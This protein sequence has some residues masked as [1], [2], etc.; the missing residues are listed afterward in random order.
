MERNEELHFL[1]ILWHLLL[2]NLKQ[3]E[4]TF[5]RTEK[6]VF[7]MVIISELHFQDSAAWGSYLAGSQ[8]LRTHCLCAKFKAT[9]LGRCDPNL[10]VGWGE[11]WDF[12]ATDFH[13][14]DL[15]VKTFHIRTH[16]CLCACFCTWIFSSCI[17]SIV[18]SQECEVIVGQRTSVLG[19]WTLTPALTV[20]IWIFWIFSGLG[21]TSKQA[22]LGAGPWVDWGYEGASLRI[23]CNGIM[24]YKHDPHLFHVLAG[25]SM[26]GLFLV[27]SNFFCVLP[28][29]SL[30]HL[31]K[32][33][34]LSIMTRT[35]S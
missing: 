8:L 17:W 28:M 33:C 4:K 10:L 31:G 32:H 35:L 22:G 30:C 23:F 29:I 21:L 9:S 25:M 16:L 19:V 2:L 20:I 15:S 11:G 26:A 34:V 1:I 13:T 14:A 27:F 5:A 3:I 7:Q 24:I 12:R 6:L 18:Y